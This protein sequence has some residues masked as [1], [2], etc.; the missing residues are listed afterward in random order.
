M[1]EGINVSISP[2]NFTLS[3]AASQELTISVDLTGVELVGEWVYGSVR[4]TSN[5]L[6]D[7]VF[8]LAVYTSGGELPDEWVIESDS[9]SG[10]QEFPLSDLVKM[11]DATFTSG[12]LVEPTITIENLVEDPSGDDPFDGNQGIMT[13]WANVPAETLWLHTE[14]LQSTS[15]DL[16]LF[17]GLDSNKDGIAQASEE[18]CSSTSPTEIEYCDLFTP[19]TGDYWIIV[20]NW[21]AGNTID[22]V[23]LKSAVIG[24]NT[25][26]VL[27]ATGDGIVASKDAQLVR[28][29]WDNV[30]AVPGTELV[31]AVGIGTRRGVPNNIGIIPVRFTKTAVAAP[32]TLVLMNGI[33]RGLTISGGGTHDR[34]VLD[35]PTGVS[36]M[37]LTSSALGENGNLDEA[38]SMEL[39]RMDFDAALANAPFAVAADTSGDPLAAA[40]GVTGSGLTL[41]MQDPAAG[42]W[43][44]VLENTSGL[45][46]DVVIQA[47]MVFN[48]TPFA[49]SA[50]LWQPSSRPNL[51]QGFD[52]A[53]TGPARALLWYTYDEDGQPAWY[54]AAGLEPVGNVW[55]A[56][57]ER[58]TNDGS[59]Q[60]ATPVGHVSVTT[61][62]E[63][64][65]IF[66]F[67]L[68]GEEGSDRMEPSSPP[69]PLCPMVAGEK[70]NYTGLWSRPEVGVG[71]TSVLTNEATQ[72]YLHYIY[73]A[74]GKPVWLL[75]AND[76]TDLP[77]A[78]VTLLQFSGYCAVC[79]GAVPTNQ[80][81]GLFSLDYADEISATWNLNYVLAF[82][83][84]GSVDR[85]DSTEK[86][87]VPLICQ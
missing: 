55:V 31:G 39:Y 53:T 20:Q 74:E 46:A 84:S 18:L 44:V 68:F 13:V 32:E 10:S 87:T 2:S 70:K 60:Q 22:E 42:R 16:D 51:S 64:D 26:S 43:Y 48:G 75:A 78:D 19:V 76:T 30:S 29:S 59:L 77:H 27:T 15:E 62:S 58:Y 40:S 86:L 17:V 24:K 1:M 33:S 45:A 50:G 14:T 6:P 65:N 25:N 8:P 81:V 82:P 80:E 57:L 41:Q 69:P 66:S 12:G 23:T 47:D 71:G 67:V 73:D 4:L 36:S 21:I 54:L 7:S 52:Y 61:L 72:G 11:P 56:N 83:L 79:T 63:Q 34:L 35:V 85:T 38:L 37:T 5:G 3:D 28:L 9:I 49:L